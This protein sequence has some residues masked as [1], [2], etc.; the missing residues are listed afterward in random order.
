MCDGEETFRI[1]T[2]ME[3]GWKEHAWEAMEHTYKHLHSDNTAGDHVKKAAQVLQH[4]NPNPSPN[5]RVRAS[6]NPGKQTDVLT[7]TPTAYRSR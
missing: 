4:P 6:P 7:L 2:D 1:A 5:P 3:F